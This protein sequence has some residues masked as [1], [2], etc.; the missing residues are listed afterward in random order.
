[1][2]D[3]RALRTFLAVCRAGTISGAARQLNIS[4]PSVSVAVAQLEHSLGT[5]LFER[6]RAGSR[7]TSGGEALR[8]RAEAMEAL[9]DDA[10]R[11][12]RLAG[13]GVRG[14]LRIGGTPGALVSLLPD[15][16]RRLERRPDPFELHVV[17]RSDAE[18]I[19]LLRKGQIELAFVTTQIEEPPADIEEETFAG[20]P[21]ALIVGK[22]NDHLPA[23]LSLRETGRLRWVLP[24]A[25]GSFRRQVDALFT[26]AD[27]PF[28]R[29]AIRCDSLLLTK[30]VVRGSE[31][32][33]VLPRDVAAAELSIGVLR[34]IAIREACFVRQVGVRRLR[35][36]RG[37]QLA[38]ELLVTLRHRP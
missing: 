30:A 10:E 21:F 1:M 6:S 9:L 4:Q 29:D 35:D 13:Q 18:L 27:L 24:E 31:R 3:P 32:V 15:A 34:A 5:T 16:I 38:E 2:I 22:R 19:D 25:R 37:S 7:L 28:P 14:L 17:E 36:G 12:A 20:D 23:S 11:E 8:R 26:A 33:T